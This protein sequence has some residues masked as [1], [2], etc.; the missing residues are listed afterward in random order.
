MAFMAFYYFLDYGLALVY[1]K[2]Y[3]TKN[4]Y[5][6]GNFFLEYENWELRDNIKLKCFI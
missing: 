4:N 6:C 2:C 5:H 1:I 3:I